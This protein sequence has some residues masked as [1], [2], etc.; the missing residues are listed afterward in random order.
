MILYADDAVPY[1]AHQTPEVLEQELN[2]GANRVTGW[3]MKSGSLIKFET[4]KN[5]TGEVQDCN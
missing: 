3:L 1:Y 5:G 2:A 4:G